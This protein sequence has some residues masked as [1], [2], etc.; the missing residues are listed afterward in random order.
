MRNTGRNSVLSFSKNSSSNR[1]K[2]CIYSKSDIDTL[3][4][5]TKTYFSDIPNKNYQTRV[6]TEVPFDKNNMGN[7][8]K[9]VPI[10]D[11]DYLEFVWIYKETH[12]HYKNDPVKYLTHLFGHEGENS[13]LSLLKAEGLATELTAGQDEE[14]HLFTTFNVRIKLTPHG[15]ENYKDVISYTFQYLNMLKKYG[16]QKW[17]FEEIQK[18]QTMKFRF[19]E[20][21]E[22]VHVAPGLSQKL[23]YYPYEDI[24]KLHYFMEDYDEEL[25]NNTIN[26]LTLDNMRIFMISQKCEP[27]C[28]LLEEW[29][30][31]KHTVA[32]FEQYIKDYY[33]GK[34]IATPKKPHHKKL[35]LPPR[36]VF[37][38]ANFDV[39]ATAQDN[40]PEDPKRIKEEKL[41]EVWF[42]RDNKFFVPKA[43]IN[44]MI[45]LR[46]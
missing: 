1:M 41:S 10:K 38:P 45:Y 14:I 44:L 2:L 40:L 16:A 25:I 22:P 35:D 42:K 4:K 31:V 43:A 17:I 39:F 29:Y 12:K 27:E 15:F 3:E 36:N 33:E 20:K 26:H 13:L 30:S 8:W 23:L 5:W 21:Q 46:E 11:D 19:L 9:L 28:N 37:I 34:H 32:P 18:T 7:F 6:F 24:L